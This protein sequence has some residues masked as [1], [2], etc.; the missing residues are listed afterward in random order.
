MMKFTDAATLSQTRKTSDGYLVTEAFAVRTGIQL[1]AGSE[2]GLI[3]RDVVRVWRPE[4]EVRDAKSL[5]TFSHAPITMGHPSEAVT[6]DNWKELAKGEVSTEATWI[7]NKIKLPL[8]VKDAEA[9]EAIDKGTR[10]L[11]AGY[12]C[13][14]E[15]VDGFTPEGE[16]YDAV[17]RNIKINHLALVPR[18]RAGSECRVEDGASSWGVSPC[19][20]KSKVEDH[21]MTM[22]NVVLGDQAAQVAAADAPKVEKFKADTLKQIADAQAASTAALEAK[23]EEIGT[24]KADKKKLEDA[25]LTPEKMTKMVADRVA[26][27]TL[28][29]GIDD[30]IECANV[31]D[32]DLRK[33]AVASAYGDELVKDSSEAEING[34]FKAL[35]KD[36]KTKQPKD[37]FADGVKN[38]VRQ[39]TND[40]WGSFLPKEA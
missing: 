29:K 9:I 40:A 26:L 17:Q 28:I 6:R 34:M 30:K 3:D 7:D 8:I 25:A 13:E 20:P 16:A 15:F 2:V 21:N 32:A 37:T 4:E 24:L 5:A 33:A 10:E 11:S 36:A 18:G 19:P 1:Y 38:G 12:T 23:D 27:E 22:L 14:L 39:P 31:S 35:A